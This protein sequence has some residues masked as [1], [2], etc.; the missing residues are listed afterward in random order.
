MHDI[1][2]STAQQQQATAERG[3]EESEGRALQ[4]PEKIQ[5]ETQDAARGLQANW[6]RG[7][8]CEIKCLLYPETKLKTWEDF[9]RHCESAT[10]R[11]RTR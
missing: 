6:G 3:T 7:A 1:G 2:S 5:D 10:P 11:R 9:K 8:I 4:D